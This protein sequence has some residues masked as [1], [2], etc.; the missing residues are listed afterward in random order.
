MFNGV[1]KS[2]LLAIYTLHCDVLVDLCQSI[3]LTESQQL[4]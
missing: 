4:V 1:Y 2:L 3:A